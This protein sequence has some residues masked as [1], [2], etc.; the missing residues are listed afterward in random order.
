[1]RHI[2]AEC[3]ASWRWLAVEPA[4]PRLPT[5]AA[6]LQQVRA[7]RRHARHPIVHHLPPSLKRQ[8]RPLGAVLRA[9][10]L[11]GKAAGVATMGVGAT[12]LAAL[13][14]AGQ[15]HDVDAWSSLCSMPRTARALWWGV[16]STLRYKSLAKAHEGQLDGDAYARALAAAHLTESQRLL[17][18]C[19]TNGGLFIKAGQ[20]CACSELCSAGV[21]AQEAVVFFCGLRAI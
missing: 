15:R 18:L 19:Q 1:M 4:W 16:G 8:Q 10:V 17:L 13:V 20:V 3:L 21:A 5:P 6:T 11:V 14:I 2:L 12:G 9:A 7:L